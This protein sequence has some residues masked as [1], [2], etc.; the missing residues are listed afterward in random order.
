M[1]PVIATLQSNGSSRI[2]APRLKGR[3]LAEL[4]GNVCY[5][6]RTYKIKPTERI[7]EGQSAS[8]GYSECEMASDYEIRSAI[9]HE[10]GQAELK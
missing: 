7:P 3:S 9:A 4:N 5:F 1:E 6:M 2:P 8:R 10:K